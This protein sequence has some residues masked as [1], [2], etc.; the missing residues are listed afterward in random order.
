MHTRSDESIGGTLLSLI[1]Y[2]TEFGST[3]DS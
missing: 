3:A 1:T 2:H